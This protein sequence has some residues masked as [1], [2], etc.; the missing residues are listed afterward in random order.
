[1]ISKEAKAAYDREYRKKNRERLRV[2]KAA[3]F[4]RTYDPVKAAKERKKNMHRHVEYCRQPEY[5]V[6]KKGYDRQRKLS[7]FGGFAEAFELLEALRK[8]IKR[9]EPNRFE[10]YKQTG[11]KQWNP[12]IQQRRRRK[13][14]EQRALVSSQS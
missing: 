14:A 13:N 7:G 11:R 1:V 4:Q 2:E 10:L 12:I 3:Y 9:Q 5:R 8:E 6:W